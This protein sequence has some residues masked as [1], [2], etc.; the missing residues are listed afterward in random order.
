V[1]AFVRENAND[2]TPI[3]APHEAEI[4]EGRTS[5]DGSTILGIVTGMV[6]FL[7][8][9]EMINAEPTSDASLGL[10]PTMA[11]IRHEAKV[12]PS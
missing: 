3:V 2:D 11:D 12:H 8:L 10:P 9:T 4:R 6:M 7:A 1:E 5:G